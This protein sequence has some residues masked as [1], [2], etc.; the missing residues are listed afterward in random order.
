MHPGHKTYLIRNKFK[1][2]IKINGEGF[3][4]FIRYNNKLNLVTTL[5]PKSTLSAGTRQAWV[6]PPKNN[7][8][9]QI[10]QDIAQENPAKTSFRKLILF[11][12]FIEQIKLE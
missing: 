6:F 1:E 4:W 5:Y 3:K 8:V 9:N 11:Y 7:L 12:D 2:A 10:K